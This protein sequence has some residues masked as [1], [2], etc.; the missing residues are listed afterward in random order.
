MPVSTTKSAPRQIVRLVLA[1]TLKIA[2]DAHLLPHEGV[3][4]DYVARA[5]DRDGY[6]RA[7]AVEQREA[8][9]LLHA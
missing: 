9:R 1:S 5:E 3:L 7:V 4:G 6:R 2:F 8:A